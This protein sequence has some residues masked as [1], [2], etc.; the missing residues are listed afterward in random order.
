M[1][2]GDFNND[3]NTDLL[4]TYYNN[5]GVGGAVFLGNGDGT[6]SPSQGTPTSFC[7]PT[8]LGPM[9]AADANSD[10]NLD[11]AMPYLDDNGFDNVDIGF[12]M[13]DGTFGGSVL[14]NCTTSNCLESRA[15]VAGDFNRDGILDMVSVPGRNYLSGDTFVHEAMSVF[16]GNGDGSFTPSPNPPS[17][18]LT[19]PS[20]LAAADFDGDGIL[21]LV[22]AD[23]GSP[24]LIVLHGNGDGTF[25]QI[26]GEPS[27]PQAPTFV[28]TAD[29]DGDGKLDL[30]ILSADGTVSILRGNGDGTFLAGAMPPVN[31][32]NSAAAIAIGDFNADG[33]LDLAV[34]GSGVSILLQ[35]PF[36]PGV[37]VDLAPSPNPANVGQLVTFTALA[38]ASS[39]TPTGSVT[40]KQGTNVLGTAPLVNGQASLTTSFPA[41]GTFPIVASYSG[42]TNYH[43]KN[44]PA[45]RQIIGKA[46]TTS[47]I[48]VN[49]TQGD[50]VF[51]LGCQVSTSGSSAP[52]GTV[53]FKNGSV[54]LGTVPLVNGTATLANVYLSPGVANFR[55]FY[56]GDA[57]NQASASQTY[58]WD[59]YVSSTTTI[60]SFSNPSH[61]GSPVNFK[62]IVTSPDGVPSG[63]VTFTAGTQTLATVTLSAGKATLVTSA[64]PVGATTVTATYNG[65]DHVFGSSNSVSQV[66]K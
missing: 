18:T 21:D 36:Q 4:V 19:D 9:I 38:W 60:T 16:L 20:F 54:S 44:S 57:S 12:G 29:M 56:N 8:R 24:A 15:V 10:G 39:P 61:H 28:T 32:G 30:I 53:T 40:F 50:Y 46:W 34:T 59:V 33:R 3:G 37:V 5:P 7:C 17:L 48:F 26:A 2:V 25:T 22:V 63:A 66:V 31:F 62:A 55:A 42:D 35:K 65:N 43:A 45:V 27:L 14:A 49:P 47:A 6:F 1:A 41:L 51:N 11:I 64:L 23:A 58:P 52:T 13:G